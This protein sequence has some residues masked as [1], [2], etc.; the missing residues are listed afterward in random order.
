LTLVAPDHLVLLAEGLIVEAEAP[1]DILE[2]ED[3]RVGG[4]AA[5]DVLGTAG[6]GRLPDHER[7]LGHVAHQV[8]VDSRSSELLAK[9]FVQAAYRGV[10][11]RRNRVDDRLGEVEEIEGGKVGELLPSVRLEAEEA[12]CLGITDEVRIG[13]AEVRWGQGRASAGVAGCRRG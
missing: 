5:G 8:R 3:E 13:R 10:R 11:P 9:P 1:R 2:V 6:S 7:V 12:N 4:V